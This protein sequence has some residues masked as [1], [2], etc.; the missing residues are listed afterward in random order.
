MS[1]NYIPDIVLGKG[2]T[3]ANKIDIVRVAMKLAFLE[4]HG[5]YIVLWGQQTFGVKIFAAFIDQMISATYIKPVVVVQKY[6]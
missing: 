6:P 2:N 3:A 4:W 1:L 5:Y